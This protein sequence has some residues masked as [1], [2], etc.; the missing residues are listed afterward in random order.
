MNNQTPT[1]QDL[2]NSV[3]ESIYYNDKS[4]TDVI[5]YIALRDINPSKYGEIIKRISQKNKSFKK[6][7]NCMEYIQSYEERCINIKQLQTT[8]EGSVRDIK[9][10]PNLNNTPT[11]GEW[12]SASEF[13][14]VEKDVA[15]QDDVKNIIKKDIVE[16][17]VA[18][19]ADIEKIASENDLNSAKTMQFIENIKIYESKNNYTMPKKTE[20]YIITFDEKIN[21]YISLFPEVGEHFNSPHMGHQN[22]DKHLLQLGTCITNHL[23]GDKIKHPLIEMMYRQIKH[24]R[25]DSETLMLERNKI[26]NSAGDILIIFKNI[27]NAIRLI[28]NKFQNINNRKY[29]MRVYIIYKNFERMGDALWEYI[30]IMFKIMRETP[31]K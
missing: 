10:I 17:N 11:D 30:D 1:T 6:Y 21:L 19:Q 20:E 16:N 25:I 31:F 23:N 9:E 13:S 24:K 29:L 12:N 14:D 7:L 2:I 18:E 26:I 3:R 15:E 8:N 28:I 4:H 22:H 5:L 27:P